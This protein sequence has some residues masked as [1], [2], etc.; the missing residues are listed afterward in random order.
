M[1]NER[2]MHFGAGTAGNKSLMS[3]RAGHGISGYAGFCPSNEA[4]M[5]PAKQGVA[6]RAGPE[7]NK[8]RAQPEWKMDTSPQQQSTYQL[9]INKSATAKPG[10]MHP[11]TTFTQVRSLG[12][13]Q[14]RSQSLA[15]KFRAAIGRSPQKTRCH[16][17]SSLLR[18][19]SSSPSRCTGRH[20]C[21][22]SSS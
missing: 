18:R 3:Y 8:D 17:R 21:T 15:L 11:M 16:R 13:S 14:S 4:I 12:E 9:T 5:I 1:G 6:E 22:P 2:L 10:A 7:A 20:S 19:S